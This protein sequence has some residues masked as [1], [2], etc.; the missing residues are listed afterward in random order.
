MMSN[1]PMTF[2]LIEK[3]SRTYVVRVTDPYWS[4]DPLMRGRYARHKVKADN[5]EVLRK[6]IMD[7]FLSKNLSVDS[8]RE[9]EVYDAKEIR[10]FGTLT[11]T[12]TIVKN[13]AVA[14]WASRGS[15]ADVDMEGVLRN[16]RRL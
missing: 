9:Y 14:K 4:S 1:V 6:K 11:V 7:E 16:K 2:G 10:K 5:L 3:P 8:T 13:Y 12:A 15:I